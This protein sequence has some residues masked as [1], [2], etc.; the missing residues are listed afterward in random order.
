MPACGR[1]D[2]QLGE[3]VFRKPEW[4]QMRRLTVRAGLWPG[5]EGRFW[6]STVISTTRTCFFRQPS[7]TKVEEV[8]RVAIGA[9]CLGP[10]P[11][12][13]AIRGPDHC[14]NGVL[15]QTPRASG[16]VAGRHF[17]SGGEAVLDKSARPPLQSSNNPG[18]AGKQWT[19]PPSFKT[20][21]DF[22]P[23]LADPGPWWRANVW[24]FHSLRHSP[25]GAQGAGSQWTGSVTMHFAVRSSASL[26]GTIRSGMKRRL[27]VRTCSSGR[28]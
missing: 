23:C 14:R 12:A 10:E 21:R 16:V 2:K 15:G 4:L 7:P 26:R 13:L 9:Q 8:R 18:K 5:S 27:F 3:R 22:N 17:D 25:L 1:G 20:N 11:S 6:A 24:V 19:S 28:S